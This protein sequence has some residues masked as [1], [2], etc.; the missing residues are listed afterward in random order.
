[1]SAVDDTAT[2]PGS[3]RGQ[4]PGWRHFLYITRTL[5][6]SEFKLRYFGTLLGYLWTFVR[7][8][9]YFLV[10]YVVFT[11]IVRVGDSVPHYPVVLLLGFVL[12]SFFA[13]ATSMGLTSLV[14]LAALSRRLDRLDYET[15]MT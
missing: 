13:D 12:Y 11:K 3:P 2:L 15:F 9:L 1:M 10:L 8:L 4:V 7:P 14:A 6:S 5:A